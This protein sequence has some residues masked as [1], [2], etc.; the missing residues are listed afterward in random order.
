[1]SD[2][3]ATRKTAFVALVVTAALATGAARAQTATAALQA[4]PVAAP[5]STAA[6]SAK[7]DP[8]VLYFEPG[9]SS[10]RGED[11]AVLDHASRLYRDGNPIVMIVSGGTD[12]TGNPVA[13]LTL[14]QHRADAVLHALVARGIPADRF[15]VLAKGQTDPAIAVPVGTA[16]SRNRRVEITWR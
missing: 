13:N 8:L 14:S 15:Q 10:V 11:V 5:A 1:M 3:A 4:P 9:S 6:P 2:L 12:A 16:E 7:P